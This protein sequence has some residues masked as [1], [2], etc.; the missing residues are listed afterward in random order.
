M[1]LTSISV[2]RGT[3]RFNSDAGLKTELHKSHPLSI[4]NWHKGGVY[5]DT[6]YI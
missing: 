3:G 2:F 4:G 6:E 5:F 1:V